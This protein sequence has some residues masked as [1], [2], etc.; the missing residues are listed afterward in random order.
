MGRI[1]VVEQK[2]RRVQISDGD[3]LEVKEDL[4][5]GEQKRLEAAGI[6]PPI[7]LAGRIISPID[8][9]V[10]DIERAL[11]FLTAWSLRNLDDKPLALDMD[12]LRS[13]DPESFDEINK[14]IL[15]H[16]AD[17]AIEKNEQKKAA[18][19]PVPTEALPTFLPSADDPTLT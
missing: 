10:H 14:A 2:T 1:R 15:K 5:T 16:V 6:K 19:K 18:L 12:G 17:R 13:I 7:M 3:W 9:E 8:W 4:N 11:I